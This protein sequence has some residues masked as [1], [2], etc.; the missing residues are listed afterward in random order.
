MSVFEAFLGGSY[1]SQSPITDQ[2]DLINWYLES[3]ESTGASSKKSLYPTP[4]VE[5]F[6][7]PSAV[8]GR[9]M[10][11]GNTTSAHVQTQT[12]RCFGVFGETLL[13]MFED[14][15]TTV[16]GMVAID[17]N[18]ATI[19]TNGDGGGQL[20]ITSGGLGYCYDLGTDVLT[21]ISGLVATSG[22]QL[23]GY[24][25]A[26]DRENSRI[27]LSDLFDGQTW[28]P[29]QF[30]DRTIGADPWR[31]MIVTPYGQIFLPGSQ[32]GEIWYNALT[33]PFPFAPDPSGL[34]SFG[35]PATFSP[36]IVA[37]TVS[38]LAQTPDGGY[39]VM[40]AR[41]FSFS[42]ISNFGMEYEMSRYQRVDDAIGQS[43]AE[44]GHIFYLLTF[45][46]ANVTWVYDQ[47]E[48]Q[49]HK[50]ATWI[51]ED[52]D[53]H[54]WRPVF[55]CFAFGHHLMADR[56]SNVIYR[57]AN[58]LPL[59]VDGRVIRRLRRAPAVQDENTR[60]VHTWF[61]L[62][63]ETG[64]GTVDDPHGDP[65][66]VMLRYSNDGGRSWS[67]ELTCGAGALGRYAT[68]VFWSRLGQARQRV[69]EVTVTDPVINWR[70]TAAYL[71]TKGSTERRVA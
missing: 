71:R 47:R 14:G 68:R 12:G 49:W 10:F 62:L 65:P 21:E 57:M 16:R 51:D 61:E 11:S 52:S 6:A 34:F 1:R 23:Y 56:E 13:E 3:S 42:R 18:P 66:L 28:D 33:F 25:V 64:L 60:I 53:Y 39:Q 50:R 48:Q 69:Y 31:A 70:I 41:G 24:F 17:S 15:T 36:A 46:S 2:E 32:T 7:S 63:M 37:E 27:R 44:Q 43:Y 5:A 26:F 59:D 20:F 54:Y 22:G 9:A 29:T 8:G 67:N 35:T 58:D 45:P 55:H 38:F 19:S 4:G 30:A 40:Q